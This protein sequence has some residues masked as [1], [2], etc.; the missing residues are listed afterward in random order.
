[1]CGWT[2][3]R[4]RQQWSLGSDLLPPRRAGRRGL[5]GV[6]ARKLAPGPLGLGACGALGGCAPQYHSGSLYVITAVGALPI[7]AI[8]VAV[9]GSGRSTAQT[10]ARRCRIGTVTLEQTSEAWTIKPGA[11]ERSDDLQGTDRVSEL[12]LLERQTAKQLSCWLVRQRTYRIS[13]SS[14][15]ARSARKRLA[16]IG[17]TRRPNRARRQSAGNWRNPDPRP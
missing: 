7:Q 9:N 4:I 15:S 2:T 17:S 12:E 8:S 14:R 11:L 5:D 16:T 13:T 6:R 1:M 10:E 3:G